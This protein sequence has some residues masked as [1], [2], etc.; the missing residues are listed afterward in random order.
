MASVVTRVLILSFT[1][2]VVPERRTIFLRA[3]LNFADLHMGWRSG[4][5]IGLASRVSFVSGCRVI[6]LPAELVSLSAE[7]VSTHVMTSVVTR[8]LMLS[9]TKQF[10]R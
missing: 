7:L 3:P 10:I 5:I 9:F 8:V 2:D 6:V 4:C 1:R